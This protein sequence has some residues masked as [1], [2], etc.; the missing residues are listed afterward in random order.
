MNP[1]K[2]YHVSHTQMSIARHYGGIRVNG[3][4]YHYNAGEDTLTRDDVWKKI[5]KVKKDEEKRMRMLKLNNE[6]VKELFE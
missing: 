2:Y 5:R 6:I 3:V 4:M 1:E